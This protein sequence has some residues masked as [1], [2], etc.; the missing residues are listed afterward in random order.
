MDLLELGICNNQFQCCLECHSFLTNPSKGSSTTGE[1]VVENDRPRRAKCNTDIFSACTTRDLHIIALR[2]KEV[3]SI[4]AEDLRVEV[5]GLLNLVPKNNQRC[6]S[7]LIRI[8]K[9]SGP[10]GIVVLDF[11]CKTMTLP[12]GATVAVSVCDSICSKE[13][14]SSSREAVGQLDSTSSILVLRYSALGVSDSGIAHAIA[15]Q[16]FAWKPALPWPLLG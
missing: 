9:L 12:D 15:Q 1:L 3:V 7:T 14:T 11:L 10:V 16:P 6:A 4:P 2:S 5:S 8:R 13:V